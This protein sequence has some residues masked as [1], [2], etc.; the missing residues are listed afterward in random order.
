[1]QYLSNCNAYKCNIYQ[2]VIPTKIPTKCNIYK[3]L[4]IPAIA[5]A[6]RMADK[7]QQL[8]CSILQ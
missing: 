3:R 2:T 7:S 8:G 4:A 1:M 6:A 5:I